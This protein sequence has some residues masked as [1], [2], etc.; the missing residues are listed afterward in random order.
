MNEKRGCTR[1]VACVNWTK[2]GLHGQGILKTSCKS[3][4]FAF[5]LII[6]YSAFH[7]ENSLLVWHDRL[8]RLATDRVVR[9]SS[10]ATDIH[11]SAVYCWLTRQNKL[12]QLSWFVSLH[13]YM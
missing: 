2:E 13:V 6:Q 7:R 4:Y 12:N 5:Q 11:V 3:H 10:L 8:R 1:I 9:H